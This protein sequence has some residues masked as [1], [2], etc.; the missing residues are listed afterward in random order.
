MRGRQRNDGLRKICGC[1]RRQW[2][3]CPHGWHL[4]F[5]H[6]G[7]DWRFSL[8]RELGR[9]V[10]SKTEARA[11]ADRLRATIRAG[12][13]RQAK[14][15]SR[16]PADGGITLR[17]FGRVYVE[18][19]CKISGKATWKND[20]GMLN[21]LATYTA[22][23][24]NVP[25]GEKALGA[26]TEDDVEAFFADLRRQGRASSTRNKYVQLCRAMFRWAVKKGYITRNPIAESETI[27]HEKMARRNRRLATDEEQNLLR[28]APPHLQRLIIAAVE[29]ACRRGELL[30]LRW[31]D[32]DLANRWI[33]IRAE[34]SKTRT[35]RE[36]PI[37]ARLGAALE[38][39]RTDA[40]GQPF[41]LQAYVFGD[42]TGRK[43]S[44][45]KRAWQTAV[46]KAHGREPQW[47]KSSLDAVSRDQ[48][49]AIN[50]HFHDLRH[51]AGSR[52]IEG[53]MPIHHVQEMLGH[54]SLE[55]TSTY[56]NVTKAGLKESISRFD[57]SRS[58][59][60]VASE[61][62]IGHPPTRNDVPQNSKQPLIN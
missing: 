19:M 5:T 31:S 58:C 46:L 28:H 35:E 3:K 11:E 20:E 56:L 62:I 55:Q 9:H 17:D 24:T 38:M 49:Q 12:E 14:E 39:A 10:E 21:Q 4:N 52:F 60:I 53:G 16:P 47:K 27:R 30:N 59:K 29:T 54:S 33:T 48:L 7:K 25:L 23:G 43:I 8:D 37:S 32:V 34:T 2:P 26:L 42:K 18:R 41:G 61:P 57:E 40:D 1:R 6:K 15:V 50:L 13:F 45:V 36:I 44:D 51:E 22:P